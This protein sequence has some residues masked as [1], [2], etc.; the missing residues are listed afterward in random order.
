MA[1]APKV[2]SGYKITIFRIPDGEM[3]LDMAVHERVAGKVD[4]LIRMTIAEDQKNFARSRIK[5]E[6]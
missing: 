5:L 4:E 2:E 3:I 1:D 6:D